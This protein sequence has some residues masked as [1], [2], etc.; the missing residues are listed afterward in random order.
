MHFHDPRNGPL[1]R[2]FWENSKQGK[3]IYRRH[4]IGKLRLSRQP[5]NSRYEASY[6]ARCRRC[7]RAD[8]QIIIKGFSRYERDI[9]GI[10]R[11][12]LDSDKQLLE[13]EVASSMLSIRFLSAKSRQMSQNLEKSSHSNLRECWEIFEELWPVDIW[14]IECFASSS[15]QFHFHSCLHLL[16]ASWLPFSVSLGSTWYRSTCWEIL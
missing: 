2:A 5:R 14:I 10:T 3:A 15:A 12:G 7:E 8:N 6:M 13:T 16:L 1:L 11:W 9:E 4:I